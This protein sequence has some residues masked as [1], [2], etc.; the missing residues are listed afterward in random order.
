MNKTPI[1]W[2]RTY[3]ADGTFV[4]GHTV[5]PVRFRP[6][7]SERTVTMCQKVSPGCA[8][9]YAEGIT[10]R[11]WPKDAA[12]PFPGYT[13]LGM[14]SGEFV[15][16]EEKL[17]QVL[18]H[19]SPT[20]IFWGDMTDLFQESVP[21]AFLDRIFAVC[22]LTPHLTHMFLTKRAERLQG[23]F[24]QLYHT[25]EIYRI[26][27]AAERMKCGGAHTPDWL[28]NYAYQPGFDTARLIPSIPNVW[29]GVST[30]NQEQADARI[31]H[32]LETPVAIR[33]I[34]AEPLLG[35]IDI[36]R[37][38]F[39]DPARQNWA[40]LNRLHLC[41]VGGESG[42]GAR[43]MHPDWARILR[44][45]CVAAEASFFFK[46]W[47]EWAPGECVERNTGTVQTAHWFNNAWSFST[48]YLSNDE[49]RVD[50]EPDLYRIGKKAAGA[51]LDGREWRE[52]P[53]VSA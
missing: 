40:R 4:E 14:V 13:A 37:Y 33:F 48:E 46:Q 35:P 45:Q 2:C 49:G 42:A 10:R 3:A 15:L 18:R 6:H 1:E 19:K 22:A 36:G 47:G 50:D 38:L 43:P 24:A 26:A 21:D 51:F 32:L 44:D 12:V 17:L 39:A 29:L 52:F 11:F 25:H 34:L 5:N 30:E 20:R 9:C 27:Q 28:S 7:G 16:D 53:V 31:P 23:Y 8:H 41:I